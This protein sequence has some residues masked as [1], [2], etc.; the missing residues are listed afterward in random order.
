M[1]LIILL[2]LSTTMAFSFASVA[3]QTDLRK[4]N[5][6]IDKNG[7]A[8]QGYDVVAFFTDGTYKAPTQI[9]T[10]TIL[11]EKLYFNYNLKVKDYWNKKQDSLIQKA[12]TNWE[13]LKKL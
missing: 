11:N 8:I 3:A 13:T 10:W 5:F 1:K 4:K 9:E 7:I 2:L 6:N 12:D